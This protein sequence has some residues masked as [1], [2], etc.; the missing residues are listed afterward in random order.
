MAPDTP[1][2]S[3]SPDDEPTEVWTSPFGT[4][5]ADAP[6]GDDT[7]PT[8]VLPPMAPGAAPVQHRPYPE[9][10]PRPE[11]SAPTEPPGSRGLKLAL[12]IA[13]GLVVVL[14]L[15]L[16]AAL[17]P[18]SSGEPAPTVEPTV[19]VSPSVS[20][21][22][23]ESAEPSASPSPSPEPE[24]EPEP[25]ETTTA[26]PPPPA[27]PQIT[28]FTAPGVVSCPTEA[29]AAEVTVSWSIINASRAWI[30]IATTDAQS[31]PYEE[32]AAA[33]TLTLPFPCSNGSQTYTITA[34]DGDG[35]TV[36]LTREVSRHLG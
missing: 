13:I 4:P 1:H 26:P 6:S 3:P 23:S 17:W 31:A 18:K 10:E 16:I 33:G 32:I 24:P 36:H 9:A 20:V 5:A 2:R 7:Q 34:I 25:T 14:A 27:G 8:Q 19:P 35:N 12:W 11:P 21:E 28:S 15:S 30:G 29:S 22:P